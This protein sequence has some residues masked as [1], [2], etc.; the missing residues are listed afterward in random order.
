MERSIQFQVPAARVRRFVAATPAAVDAG[1]NVSF[2]LLILFLLMLYSNIAVV[3]PSLDSFRPS[4][5]V[6]VA[7]LVMLVIELGQSRQSFKLMWPQST[8]VLAFL[9][10]CVISS[11]SAIYAKKAFDTTTDLAKIILIYILLEST[12][13]TEKRLRAFLLTMAAGS[14]FPALG[15]IYNYTHGVLVEGS[16][17]AW[18]GIFANPN[19]NAYSLLIIIP[20]A[21]AI[22]STSRWHIRIALWGVIAVL[23]LAIFLTFS[24]GGL[25]GLFAVLGLMGWKQRSPI[26]RTAMI[27]GLIGSIFVVGVFWQRKDGFEDISKDTTFNQR[28]A[29]I[30]AG[31]LMFLHNPL[32]GVGPGCSMVAY[33]LYVPKD[34]HCGC[35]DQLV[36]HNSFIQVLSELGALGFVPFMLFLGLALF[37]AW[38]MERGPMSSYGAALGTALCGF[39]VCSLSGGFTYT[40]WPYLLVGLIAAAKGISDSRVAEQ[41]TGSSGRA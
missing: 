6:A 3:I 23:I 24:R 32:L 10:I 11:F 15:T 12:I 14:L 29:T 30:Q 4:L 38:K 40:W 35:Q 37:H 7:A 20:I 18:K 19:E 28:I 26:I 17:A 22:A 8:M 39:L 34:A 27:A 13:V 33:P 1:P 25:V 16:R 9:G 5:L 2:K 21:A 41:Q 36:I 31:G